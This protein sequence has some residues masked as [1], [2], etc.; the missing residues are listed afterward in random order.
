M[1]YDGW[2]LMALS[3]KKRLYRALQKL[4]FARSLLHTMVT[5]GGCS[6]L[7]RYDE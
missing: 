1:T 3:A 4:K 7:R 5:G 6:L 2:S